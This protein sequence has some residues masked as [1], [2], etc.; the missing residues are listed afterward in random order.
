MAVTIGLAGSLIAVPANAAVDDYDW[1]T[2][3]N[4]STVAP[5]TSATFNSF[6]QPSVNE[7]GLVAFRAR[8]Q[9]PSPIRGV[10]TRN[11][12][13]GSSSVVTI[14]EVGDTVPQPNNLDGTFTEFPSF[15]RI[16]MTG[17]TVGTRGQS[18]PVWEYA[19][20]DTT[21]TSVGTSGVYATLNG[22]LTTGASLLGA[23]PGQEIYSVPGAPSGTRFDQF[24]GAPAVDGTTVAFKGNYTDGDG[25][26]GIFFRDVAQPTA[27]TQV[28]ASSDTVIPGQSSGSVQFGSTAPPSAADGRVVFLGLD[29]EE[30]PTLGGIYLAPLEPSPTLTTLVAIGDQVP[31]AAVEDVF[32]KIGEALS[33]D[34][35][36]VAFA[37]SW[38]TETTTIT[39]T[40]P[41]DGNADLI[42][43]CNETYPSGFTTEVPVNQGIFV[44]DTVTSEL[45]RA[46]ATGATFGSFL[47]WVFSGAPPE[48]GGGE[49]E[50]ME[51]P[52]WR[53]SSFVAVTSISSGFQV[54]FKGSPVAGGSGIYVGQ[55]PGPVE[56]F[57]TIV[58]TSTDGPSID[59]QAPAGSLVSVVGLER[60]GF[61]G[62][63]LA[64]SISM[65]NTA[66]TESW[67]GV[68]VTTVQPFSVSRLAGADR[69][70]TSAAISAANY[71]AEAPVAYIASG[72]E[73][74]DAL[75]GAPVAGMQEGPVL[76]VRLTSIPDV[77]KAEL[78]RL[79]PSRIVVLGGTGVVS[80]AVQTALQG[81]TSG[82]VTRLAGLDRYGTSA[83]I[84]AANFDP[85]VPS[86]YIASGEDFPDALSGAA[87]AGKLEVPVLLVRRDSIPATVQA[88]LTR[89]APGAIVILGGSGIVSDEVATALQSST[90][91]SVT[92][93]AGPDRYATS[94]AISAANFAPGVPVVYIASGE[95]FPD[96]L[97][98]AAVA[99]MQEVPV[100]LVRRDSIPD[101]VI[102]E[103]TRLAP[104]KIVILGGTGVVSELV[105]QQLYSY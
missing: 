64:L 60:E 47:Y 57:E 6:N 52:R 15:P 76:L 12:A 58:D 13:S 103:L 61:R 87:V 42:A 11:S 44:Y 77:V 68:Y 54:A 18:T 79:Q 5:G 62:Q 75:S 37:G 93:L 69:Y 56:R 22:A 33:F 74:P 45:S 17:S 23:V 97:S 32:T 49:D 2:V 66:T 105:S 20:P 70:A 95:G 35:R 27:A 91:G 102:A 39:L 59:P 96:A 85:G 38:G 89:L 88:E 14:A 9:G 34:G 73:F 94:A 72:A 30:A 25:K 71:A 51:P 46:A 41:A 24:P 28:I 1:T 104:A 26:T 82:S 86:V 92:R 31:G 98:G 67:A 21:T 40:C 36:Y 10:Y 16:D 78:N 90:S 4:S 55:G 3:A 80:S 99:G 19:L 53:S 100:L 50:T 7:A 84:S 43:Y 29:N 83:A 48:V 65:L 81:Y 63:T 8:T 101:E